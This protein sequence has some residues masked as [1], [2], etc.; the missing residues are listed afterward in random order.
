MRVRRTVRTAR[1][2]AQDLRREADNRLRYG[3]GA[4]Q[5]SERLWIDPLAVDRAFSWFEARSARVVTTWPPAPGMPFDEHRHVAFALARWRQGVPW[6]ETGA[7]EYMTAQIARRGSQDGCRTPQDVLRRFAR[8]DALYE[9]VGR[10][11]RL[12]TRSELEPR[13][14]R[15]DG[16]ILVHVGPDGAFVAGDSGKHRLTIARLHQLPSIPV[17]LGEIHRDALPL[18]ASLRRPR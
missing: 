7:V 16:G 1:L 9:T 2:R 4:P 10:E 5:V 12:R 6:T 11:R 18:L 13:A 3:R 8:L 15:E 14:F 17:R